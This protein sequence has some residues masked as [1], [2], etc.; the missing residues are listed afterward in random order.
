MNLPESPKPLEDDPAYHSHKPGERRL[1]EDPV[2]FPEKK[3]EDHPLKPDAE[4]AE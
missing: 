3:A 4:E 2:V 1:S